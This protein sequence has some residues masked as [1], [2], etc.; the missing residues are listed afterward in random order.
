MK[1]SIII[2]TRNRSKF[3]KRAID[4]AYYQTYA[5]TEVIISNN[6]SSDNT[7]QILNELKN[8]YPSLNIVEHNHLLS[9]NEHW[10]KVI[11]EHSSGD[12]ILLIPDDDVLIDKDYIHRAV[13]LFK[14]YNTIGLVFANYYNVNEN[15]EVISKVEAKFNEFIPKEYFFENYNKTLFGIKGIGVSHLTTLF[16]RNAYNGVGGF[17][18]ECMCPDTYYGLRYF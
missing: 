3:L 5:N 7:S 1:V 4:H 12:L 16:S 14:K 10:N 6:A 17:D 13:N 18:L 9:L 11:I 2:P 8:Q 15:F